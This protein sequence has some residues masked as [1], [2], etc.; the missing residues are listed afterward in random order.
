MKRIKRKQLKEDELVTT[1]NKIIRFVQRRARELVALGVVVVLVILV[2]VGV[3]LVKAHNVKKESRLLAQIIELRA[4]L[5][6]NPEKVEKLQQLAGKGKFS[7][8]S[9]ILL[10]GYRIEKGDF[11]QAE[12]ALQKVSE[13]KKDIFYYQAQDMLAQIYAKQKKFDK[14]VGIYQKIQKQNPK[15]YV[16]DALLFH[17]AQVWEQKGE[18]EKALDL[19]KKVKEEYPQTYFGY[20]ASQKVERLEGKK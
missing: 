14:A 8:L 16:M 11:D 5:E 9:F 18:T 17:Q 7:R 20:D 1:F 3:R 12:Q 15:K 2:F 10:A 6:E 13:G 19:Y 4:E